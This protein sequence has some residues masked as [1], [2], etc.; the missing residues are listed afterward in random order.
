MR[1]SGGEMA[2]VVS[3]ASGEE[4]DEGGKK[5]RSFHGACRGCLA[6]ADFARIGSGD[7][8]SLRAGWHDG[9]GRTQD[10]LHDGVW[11][12]VAERVRVVAT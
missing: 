3:R 9:N 2:G 11:N 10:A 1:A 6:R 7:I 12:A 4:P 8:Q 5:E